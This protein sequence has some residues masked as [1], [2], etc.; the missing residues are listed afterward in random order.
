M[1][2]D[3]GD[4]CTSCG[5]DTAMG[6]GRF[7]NR[8]PSICDGTLTIHIMDEIPRQVDVEGYMCE[9]CEKSPH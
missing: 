3:I 4:F 5:K 2:V 9:E 6:S 7:V 1:K 8:I